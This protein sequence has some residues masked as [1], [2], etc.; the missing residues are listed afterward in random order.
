MVVYPSSELFQHFDTKIKAYQLLQDACL[1]LYRLKKKHKHLVDNKECVS[2]FN[3]ILIFAKT[4]TDI[5]F[6]K[7]SVVNVY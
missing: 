2:M 1:T 4:F 7:I 3:I 6:C 5:L